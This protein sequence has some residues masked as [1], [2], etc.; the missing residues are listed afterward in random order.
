VV[1]E[2]VVGSIVLVL[3]NIVVL[4]LELELDT[5]TMHIRLTK[6]ISQQVDQSMPL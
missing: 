3:D 6:M 2:V 4:V 5:L 1:K